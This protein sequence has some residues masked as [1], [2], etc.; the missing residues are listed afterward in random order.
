MP[1]ATSRRRHF[2]LAEFDRNAMDRIV[3]ALHFMNDG[4]ELRSASLLARSGRQAASYFWERLML[5]KRQALFALL[6]D[7]DHRRSDG[8]GDDTS[9]NSA[10]ALADR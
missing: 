5:R 2:A 9:S 6:D 8:S 3:A 4:R 7:R 10:I 1:C